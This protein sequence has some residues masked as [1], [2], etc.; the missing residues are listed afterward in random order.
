MCMALAGSGSRGSGG[1]QNSGGGLKVGANVGWA[2]AEVVWAA[3][4]SHR[5][6]VPYRLCKLTRYLQ[7]TL[8]PAG[9]RKL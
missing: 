2:L 1:R 6:P 9:V 4:R 5:V 7:D 8:T 3:R